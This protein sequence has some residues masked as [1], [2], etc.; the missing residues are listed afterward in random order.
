MRLAGSLRRSFWSG[1]ASRAIVMGCRA[2]HRDSNLAEQ[3]I[4]GTPDM[5]PTGIK[6]AAAKAGLTRRPS[7]SRRCS[8]ANKPVNSGSTARCFAQYMKIH[9]LEAT[10]GQLYSQMPRYATADG[11][12]TNDEAKALKA[13]T[14]A[15]DNPARNVWIKETALRPR[16]TRA[17]WPIRSRCSGSSSASRCC[18]AG[19]GFAI[20]VDR[21]LAAQPRHRAE[22]PQAARARAVRP[23]SHH[24]HAHR[25]VTS[26]IAA[27]SS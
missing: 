18:S 11:K 26:S 1:S 7:R 24:P 2:Q 19:V 10:G 3:Q 4:V 8:V 25:S 15:Q 22:V 12:G 9:A 14:A 27:T 20:L 13:R 17:T 21:R 5:T 16:S 23:R 6:G